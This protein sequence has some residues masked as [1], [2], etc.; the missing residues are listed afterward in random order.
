MSVQSTHCGNDKVLWPQIARCQA[1]KRATLVIVIHFASDS[2]D[3]LTIGLEHTLP[4]SSIGR[5]KYI[6]KRL[7]SEKA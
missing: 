6:D 5:A 1:N 4:L 3:H 7:V 2:L